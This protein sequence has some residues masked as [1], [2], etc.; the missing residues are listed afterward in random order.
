V[1]TRERATVQRGLTQNL[2]AELAGVRS[3]LKPGLA[4]YYDLFIDTFFVENLKTLLH[5]H[6]FPERDVDIR[7]LLVESPHLPTLNLD[8]LLSA[9]TVHRL[10]QLL[11]DHRVKPNLLP[12]LVELDDTRDFFTAEARIDC[13]MYSSVLDCADRAPITVR[14]QARDL[15][16]LEIDIRNLIMLLR[17]A[18][19]YHIPAEG[20]R[21][22]FVEGGGLLS[23]S[24]LKELD[25]VE[26]SQAVVARLPSP[27]GPRLAPLRDRELYLSENA[28]WDLLYDRARALFRDFNRPETAV[29]AFPYLKRFEA[30]NLAR[31]FEGFHF[32]LPAPVIRSMMIGLRH[33]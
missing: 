17:N 11:P 27:F 7:L 5:Y 22:L 2:I 23:S 12:I 4:A 18:A 26:T 8:G 19:L 6:W 20:L 28:L 25:G 13:L 29:V 33:A 24:I 16:S 15:L 32:G 30:I 21:E 14:K 3:L 31:V 9:P 1:D 10:Y